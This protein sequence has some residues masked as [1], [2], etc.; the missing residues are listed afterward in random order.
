MLMKRQKLTK[1]SFML[2][3]LIF[4]ICASTLTAEAKKKVY[5]NGDSYDGKWKRGAPNGLGTMTYANGDCYVGDWVLGAI[6]GNGKMTYANGD[7]YD[8][9]WAESKRTGQGRMVYKNGN[10]YNGSW[11]NN[12]HH[13]QGKMIYNDGHQFEGEWTNG[14]FTN[15]TIV[16]PN[17]DKYSGAWVNGSPQNGAM[18]YANRSYFKGEWKDSQPY[19]G[20]GK[21]ATT[22]YSFNGEWLN[23]N[24]YNGSGNATIGDNIYDG[25]WING[26]FIGDCTLKI[27]HNTLLEFNG[28]KR[29]DKTYQGIAKYKN[30]LIYEGSL[31]EEM[32]RE[33]SAKLKYNGTSKAEL[34]GE[35]DND[36]CIKG[37][38]WYKTEK[39][40]FTIENVDPSSNLYYIKV[41]D[42]IGT[43]IYSDTISHNADYIL[44]TYIF[45]IET[46]IN[47]KLQ[48]EFYDKHLK[49]Q[50]FY[51][52]TEKMPKTLQEFSMF[53]D[54]S[55]LS[56]I[57]TIIFSNENTMKYGA[58][59]YINKHKIKNTNRGYLLQQS[60]YAE[61]LRVMG[62]NR[63]Y[64]VEG[65]AIIINGEKYIFNANNKTLYNAEE[66]Q[67]LAMSTWDKIE[68]ILTKKI[69]NDMLR[70]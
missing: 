29:S 34:I 4:S 52:C 62:G 3:A 20:N 68:K 8:G 40:T 59:Y 10:V 11:I 64:K 15:G 63:N 53:I 50:S 57:K 6:T 60:G 42:G 24:F 13:G 7:C 21:I 36:R 18:T 66:D 39:E 44:S 27:K 38:G 51:L 49:G 1:T 19:S 23:G 30:N 70:F 61:K 16:Y 67:T 47:E 2:I 54:L 43:E 37:N 58:L 32:Q 31:N 9:T 28:E 55:S 33:G 5:E 46:K 48:A 25:E 45:D 12:N 26:C 14:E 22:S 56:L 17:G 41:Y 35:W 69:D 65:N